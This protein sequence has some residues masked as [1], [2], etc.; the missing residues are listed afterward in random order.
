MIMIIIIMIIIMIIII[1]I[2]IIIMTIIISYILR[3]I[4]QNIYLLKLIYL[5]FC[6]GMNYGILVI[7]S[8]KTRK[9]RATS[10]RWT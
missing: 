9:I 2:M 3:N 10:L 6:F 5:N 7:K 4:L 8:H 1:I